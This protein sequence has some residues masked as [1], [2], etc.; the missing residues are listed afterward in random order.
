MLLPASPPTH[1][2]PTCA[3]LQ[4]PADYSYGKKEATYGAEAD[5]N[6][7]LSIINGV[8]GGHKKNYDN[9]VIQVRRKLSVHASLAACDSL[10]VPEDVDPV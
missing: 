9:G 10:S 7:A 6:V 8:N 3:P 1:P 5:I 2:T 4:E